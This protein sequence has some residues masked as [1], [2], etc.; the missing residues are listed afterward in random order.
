MPKSVKNTPNLPS[1]DQYKV[2]TK[3][4]MH[5]NQHQNTRKMPWK[6]EKDPYKIWLSEVIL[7]QTR[8]DQGLAYFNR[9]VEKYPTVVQLAQAKDETV[10]KLWEGLGYYSRCRNLLVTARYVAFELGGVFPADYTA[11]LQLKGVG[12]YTAAAIAS[13]A[14]N[15][16]HAVLDGNVF[17]VIARYFGIEEATDTLAGKQ[18]FTGI[19]NALLAKNAPGLYNQA[20]MDFGATICKPALPACATCALQKNCVALKMGTVNILPV[21]SK[22]ILKK[23]RWLYYFVFKHQQSVGITQRVN[24][25]IWQGLHEFYL[26]ESTKSIHWSPPI[27]EEWLQTQLGIKRATITS[28]SAPQKQQLTHQLI[29][30]LFIEIELTQIPESLKGLS[31]VSAKQAN[32]LAFPRFITAYLNGV[33]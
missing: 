23:T 19:A 11:L 3:Q 15:L 12:P 1:K 17:R 7:Q 16:P 14:F 10:F 30:G 32:Q 21:K 9:F 26:V 24:K 28:I 2:F 8:V 27:I 33:N 29:N 18:Q 22:T 31:W 20:I 4:L 5:W 25:D 6:G 13:F